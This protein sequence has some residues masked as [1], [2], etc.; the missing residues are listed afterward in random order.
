MVDDQCWSFVC[1]LAGVGVFDSEGVGVAQ[2]PEDW[3]GCL[4][5]VVMV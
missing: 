1:S 5:L 4:I 3:V 2:C